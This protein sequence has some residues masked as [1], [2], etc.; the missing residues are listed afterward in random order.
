MAI[1]NAWTSAALASYESTQLALDKPLI[2]SQAIPISPDYA[3]WVDDGQV[4]AGDLATWTDR[5]ATA[6]PA[7]RAYD[8]YPGYV[9]KQSGTND[10]VWYYCI[11]AGAHVEFDCAFLVGG[12][13]G[14]LALA[15]DVVLQIADDN[16]FTT[17]L[18][19][20]GNFGTPT[21]DGRLA[22][23]DLNHGGDAQRY[24]AQFIRVKFDKTGTNITPE[25]GQLVLG[26]RRQL[27]FKPSRPYDQ[28]AYNENSSLVDTEGGILHKSVY[29]RRGRELAGEFVITDS[30]YRDDLIGFFRNCT[31]SFVWIDA[32]STAPASFHLM[33]RDG[34]FGIPEVAANTYKYT[35][36]AHEQGPESSYLDVET[37]G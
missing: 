21:D 17:D 6:Y 7:Y 12:N 23:L 26:R 25:I 18:Q 15:A 22:D 30:T 29:A 33:M 16:D 10:D 35:I 34:P 36:V 11:D 9:T 4:G 8:G 31:G 24:S 2:A 3:K 37:N 20:I 1:T 14:T 19:S 13:W 28:Y 32:P 5:S 27:E